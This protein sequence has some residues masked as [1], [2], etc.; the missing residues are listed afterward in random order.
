MFN[1]SRQHC[2]CSQVVGSEVVVLYSCEMYKGQPGWR[3]GEQA[4]CLFRKGKSPSAGP[5]A[6]CSVVRLAKPDL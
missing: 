1:G 4:G 5:A 3:N 2:S 6:A